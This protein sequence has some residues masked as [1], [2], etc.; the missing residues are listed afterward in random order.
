LPLSCCLAGRSALPLDPGDGGCR[1]MPREPQGQA[2]EPTKS[3]VDEAAECARLGCRV[4]W[5][6][7]RLGVGHARNRPA[8]SL[9]PGRGG[10]TRLPPRGPLAARSR[11]PH[12]SCSANLGGIATPPA[13][14]L[15]ATLTVRA[16]RLLGEYLKDGGS[17]Q[18]APAADGYARRQVGESL[19]AGS[20]ARPGGAVD[21]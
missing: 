5:R 2:V 21:E 14:S 6:R 13:R 18:G 16:A 1:G 9:H 8:R 20:V 17:Q 12:D 19:A 10:R 3:A 4:G 15:H 7:L 11:P